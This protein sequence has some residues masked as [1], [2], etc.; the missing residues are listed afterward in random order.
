MADG[1]TA[2][3]QREGAGRVKPDHNANQRTL[4]EEMP[5]I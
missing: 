3:P 5:W 1:A 2:A 4:G